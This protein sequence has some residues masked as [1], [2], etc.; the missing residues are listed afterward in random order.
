MSKQKKQELTFTLRNLAFSEVFGGI[1]TSF[2]FATSISFDEYSA[3]DHA[4][5]SKYK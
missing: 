1:L 4:Y 5:G 3:L 2:A